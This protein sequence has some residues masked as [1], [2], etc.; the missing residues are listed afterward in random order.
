MNESSEHSLADC[1]LQNKKTMMV[2]FR[3]PSDGK[4][5]LFL[6]DFEL[7]QQLSQLRISYLIWCDLLPFYGRR[8]E[9]PSYLEDRRFLPIMLEESDSYSGKYDLFFLLRNCLPDKAAARNA[10]LFYQRR[11]DRLMGDLTY[12]MK[13]RLAASFGGVADR[14]RKHL[15]KKASGI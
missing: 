7:K 11:E 10:F 2:V 15:G 13:S 1:N 8:K 6:E 14:E 4:V 3:R 9:D 5:S 12:I